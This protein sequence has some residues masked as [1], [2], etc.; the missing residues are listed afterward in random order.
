MHHLNGL[1]RGV[2]FRS[3]GLSVTRQGKIHLWVPTGLFCPLYAADPQLAPDPHPHPHLCLQGCL[4]GQMAPLELRWWSRR[5]EG[6]QAANS[7]L[8]ECLGG[9]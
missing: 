6:L 2:G 7:H 5:H 3:K 9:E 8:D 1:L 4:G